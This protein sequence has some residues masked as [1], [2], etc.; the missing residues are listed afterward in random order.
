MY[1]TKKPDF[2]NWDEIN[3]GISVI[4]DWPEGLTI[5]YSKDR[6]EG[7]ILTDQITN[8]MSWLIASEKF[9]TSLEQLD[10][11]F[12]EFL[13]VSFLD[14]KGRDRKEPYWIINFTK[15]FPAVD[16]SKSVCEDSVGGTLDY[17][18]KLVLTEEIQKN[19]PPIFCLEEQPSLFLFREDFKSK[20]EKNGLTG[21][22]FVPTDE[23]KTID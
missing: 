18:E 10:L 23:F 6:P 4:N 8:V 13:P 21:F 19:G 9:K 12:I 17:F 20:I 11:D 22:R 5:Q 7:I 1:V 3:D 15:L 16:R 14:H 2:D